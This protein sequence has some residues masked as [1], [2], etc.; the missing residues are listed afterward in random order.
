MTLSNSDWAKPESADA[1]RA[2]IDE[3]LRLKVLA[4]VDSNGQMAYLLNLHFSRNLILGFSKPLIPWSDKS[5]NTN[6]EEQSSIT[7]DFLKA[8]S[9]E[10][11]ES[12]LYYLVGAAGK[13]KVADTVKNFFS[14]TGLMTQMTSSPASLSISAKGYEYLL[15]DQKEQVWMFIEEALKLVREEAQKL[16]ILALLFMLS[17]CSFGASYEMQAVTGI[18][19]QLLY[20]LSHLG[21]LYISSSS[22]T[23]NTSSSTQKLFYPSQLLIHLLHQKNQ[24]EISIDNITSRLLDESHI[25]ILVETNFQV[26]AYVT[27]ELYLAILQIFIEV[28]TRFPNAVLGFITRAKSKEAYSRGITSSQILHFLTVHAHPLVRKKEEGKQ[29]DGNGNFVPANVRAQLL[30]WEREKDRMMSTDSVLFDFSKGGFQSGAT[31]REVLSIAHQL[32]LK[33]LWSDVKTGKLIVDKKSVAAL[34]TACAKKGFVI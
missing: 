31:C 25:S 10:A 24:N 11:W 33:I 1:H 13:G 28:S 20:E 18:Q 30:L 3:L 14:R 8:R 23:L 34:E 9:D 5:Y 27:S 17:Y 4:K 26:M 16:E 22:A 19:R 32:E 7:V 6:L 29:S 2:A 12:L 21:L 15:R